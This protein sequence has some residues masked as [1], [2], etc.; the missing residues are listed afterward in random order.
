[1]LITEGIFCYQTFMV[2]DFVNQHGRPFIKLQKCVIH[3]KWPFQL[4]KDHVERM[5]FNKR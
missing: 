5:N 1:M 2:Y 3:N 4:E